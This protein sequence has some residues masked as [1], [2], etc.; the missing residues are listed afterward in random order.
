MKSVFVLVVVIC[1]AHARIIEPGQKVIEKL[2]HGVNPE[3]KIITA[4][5]GSSVVCFHCEEE[6]AAEWYTSGVFYQIYPKSFKDS[7]G[8]GYGD[9]MGI[10]ENLEHLKNLGVDGVWLSPCFESPQKDGGYD[11]SDFRR[12]DPIFGTM[13]DMRH[14]ILTAKRLK[15]KLILDF[16]PNHSSDQHEWFKQSVEGIAPYDDYYVWVDGKNCREQP[17]MEEDGIPCDPPNNW[18]SVFAGSQWEW[19][20]KREKFY[21]HQFIVEQ[22][23]LNFRNPRV[24]EELKN[25][26]LFWLEMGIDGFRVDAINHGLEDPELR[27]EYLLSPNGDPTNWNDI[28]HNMT[29]DLPES[30]DLVYDWRDVLDEFALI[31]ELEPK[32]LMTEAYPIVPENVFSWFG[33]ENRLGSQIA[34]NFAFIAYITAESTA[35]DYAKNIQTWLDSVPSYAQ[36]NWVMGNHDRPRIGTRFGEDRR[37]QLA[38]L[39]L[40]L[41]GISVIYY[42]EEIGMINNP[43]ISWA[44]TQDPQACNTND[45]YF[46]EVSRDP[47]RTPMQWDDTLNAGFSSGPTTWLPVHENYRTLNLKAQLDEPTSIYNLYRNLIQLKRTNAF[48]FG[49]TIVKSFNDDI[50]G[51]LRYSGD[52]VYVVALNVGNEGH[53]IDVTQISDK[54]EGLDVATLILANN[55][56]NRDFDN[57]FADPSPHPSFNSEKVY[58]APNDAVVLLLGKTPEPEPEPKPDDDDDGAAAI[59]VSVALLGFT[60]IQLFL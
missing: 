43:E 3:G 31:Q 57:D 29:M 42:G 26:L 27:D 14:L 5:D 6:P 44:E 13:D 35:E 21:H 23:D 46:Q 4:S 15:I 37:E 41:P 45:T 30:Y 20:W 54:S 47:V 58:L 40:L 2:V 7:N 9:L 60:V 48:K 10:A 49:Q 38:I 1:L 8:D 16:V 34:F 24:Q 56:F 52:E 50:F 51:F 55:A 19:N 53:F 32:I 22:P 28:Y 25:I 39:S 12:V 11:I 36:P 33:N 59:S 18:V 17:W